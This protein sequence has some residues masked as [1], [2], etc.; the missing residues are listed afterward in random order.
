M[1]TELIEKQLVDAGL[2]K[3]SIERMINHY[4]NMRFYLSISK[5]EE[6]GLHVGKFCENT[7]NLILN[8]LGQDIELKPELGKILDKIEKVNNIPNVDPMIKITIPRILKAAY[9]MRSKR[10]AVHVNLTIPV[11][12]VD[13]NLAVEMCT[14][15]ISELIRVYGSVQ[16]MEIAYNL[17]SSLSET[18]SPYVDTYE[19]K[20]LIM[21]NK[22]TVPQEILVHLLIARDDVL[23]EDLVKWIPNTN[24]NHIRTVLRQLEKKRELHYTD[25]KSKITP[26]GAAKAI[27]II[28][29]NFAE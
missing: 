21:S 2:H 5:F 9:D 12:H 26:L 19:G 18:I 29:E 4:K 17:I 15:I 6:V 16:D 13:S 11:N 28:Q 1:V 7:G 23:I 27:E 3:D 22:L 14:W 8:I 20:K 24:Q 25:Q 10:D